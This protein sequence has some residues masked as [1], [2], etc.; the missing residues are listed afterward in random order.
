MS[1]SSALSKL[2]SLCIQVKSGRSQT[3]KTSA[4]LQSAVGGRKRNV[5]GQSCSVQPRAL[6]SLQFLNLNLTF[7]VLMKMYLSRKEDRVYMTV[8]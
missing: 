6:K 3:F 1:V 4:L 7:Q 2:A 8:Y 5:I